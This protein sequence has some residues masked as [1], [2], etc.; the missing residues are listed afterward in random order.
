MDLEFLLPIIWSII[1]AIGV[2]VYVIL[3]GFDLGV[4]ILFPWIKDEQ[5]KTLMMNSIAPFWDG[6]ETWLVLG[7]VGLF[8]AFPYVYATLLPIMYIPLTI[9]LIAIALRGVSFE[10]RFKAEHSK[11]L[12]DAVFA[13][14]SILMAFCQGIV[15]GTFVQ[16]FKMIGKEFIGG[17]FDWATPFSFFCGIALVIGY[18]LLGA[19]WL[20]YKTEGDLQRKMYNFAFKLAIAIIICIGIVSLWTPL[21]SQ[22]IFERWFGKN[23]KILIWL[24]LITAIISLALLYSI[25]KRKEL[26]PFVYSIALFI[27]SY[28]GLGI[29]IWPYV[30][31]RSV[32]IWQASSSVDSQLFTLVGAL[33]VLPCVLIYTVK[34][35]RLF[36][37]KVKAVDGYPV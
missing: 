8:V 31:P 23:F 30:I 5:H 16:G 2:V 25:I 10:F 4:G 28:M 21:I 29:S 24:P 19:T 20:I 22:G 3:D 36:K 17:S 32:N 18:A 14:G 6:N 26:K 27:L 33:I 34:I 13:V 12:W 7:G 15:L 1:I 37:G 35:Y 9:F 11:P